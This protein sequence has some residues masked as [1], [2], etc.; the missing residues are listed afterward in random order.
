MYNETQADSGGPGE[1]QGA[2]LQPPRTPQVSAQKTRQILCVMRMPP[3]L[4]GHGGS[5]RAWRLVEALRPHGKVHFVL[6][7]RSQDDDCVYT[8]LA[9]LEPLVESITRINV[10]GWQGT[11]KR[12]FGFIP[13]KLCDLYN[14]RSH[15]APQLSHAELAGIAERLPLRNPDIVF[16]GRLCSAVIMQSLMDRG[17]LS[18]T[19]RLVDFDDIMSKFR[20]RQAR[21]SGSTMNFF[22]RAHARVDGRIIARAEKQMARSWHGVSVCTDEDVASLRAAHPDATVIKIPNVV[23]RDFLPPRVRDGEFRLLFAGN[24]SF[25]ANTEGLRVFVEHGWPQLLR[26]VPEAKLTVVG[27]NPS[28]EV[29]DLATAHG[30]PLHA[31]VPSLQPFYADCDVVIAPILFGSGTRIKILEAMAYG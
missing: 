24:L 31:N 17:L 7:Y 15:E 20:M 22:R 29:V 27:L 13:A 21:S 11:L 6:V 14:M 16:A 18:S 23:C 1:V 5:Q 19:L 26:L 3:D 9:P 12:P 4:D 30:F 25:S 28:T 10:A 8:S 2:V